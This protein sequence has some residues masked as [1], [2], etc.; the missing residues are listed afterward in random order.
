M[1]L[2]VGSQGKKNHLPTIV[3][4]HGLLP[5]CFPGGSLSLLMPIF[6]PLLKKRIILLLMLNDKSLSS[7]V[8]I[9]L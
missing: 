9:D 4:P 8:H 7:H 1:G 6:L 3:K 5:K 2:T